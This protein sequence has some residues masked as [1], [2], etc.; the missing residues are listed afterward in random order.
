MTYQLEYKRD[1]SGF[2]EVGLAGE[3]LGPRNLVYLN[4]SGVWVKADSNSYDTMPVVGI[5][6]GGIRSGQRGMILLEGF[7]GDSDWSWTPGAELYASN[8][9]GGIVDT[10]FD[11]R[12]IVGRAVENDLI[13]FKREPIESI[14]YYTGT[15][16]ELWCLNRETHC[17]QV[18][19]GTEWFAV[20]SDPAENIEDDF[21]G[22]FD[23]TALG[24]A[25]IISDNAWYA[26]KVGAGTFTAN[27]GARSGMRI[28]TGGTTN[29]ANLFTNGDNSGSVYVWN[30]ANQPHG[31]YKI[32]FPDAVDNMKVLAVMYEDANNY[33]GIRYDTSVDAN[34]HFITKDG[35]GA[36]NEEDT[37]LGAPDSDFHEVYF[38]MPTDGS[39]RFYYEGLANLTHT[40]HIPTGDLTFYVYV[41][42]LENDAKIIDISHFQINQVSA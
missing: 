10:P 38:K 14:T 23:L 30:Q 2:Y 21:I 15:H 29:N 19:K 16:R 3:T 26:N 8:V 1:G 39:V 41:E 6:I 27:S 11:A 22:V 4:S 9:A 24:I 33:F 37:S 36:G 20:R 31:N 34:L 17:I 32:R 12:Q 42:T 40:T 5:T 28:T 7:I 18:K 35:V 13:Y 25:T